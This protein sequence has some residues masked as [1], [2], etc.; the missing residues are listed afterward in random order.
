MS[1]ERILILAV[2]AAAAVTA[3]FPVPSVEARQSGGTVVVLTGSDPT[4]PIP[5]VGTSSSSNADVADQLFLRLVGLGSSLRTAGDDAMV[6]QLAA[7]WRRID[8]VTVLFELDPRARW[9]DGVPVTAEDVAFTWTLMT[10]P[11]L[12]SNAA[13]LEPIA[14]VEA[15][16]RGTVR[17]RYRRPFNEQVYL[18]G[19]NIQPVPAHL[20]RGIR[21]EE[22]AT[23]AFAARPVGNGPFRWERRVP[24]Q[25]VELRADTAFFLGRP[26]IAKVMFRYAQSEEARLNL[27]LSGSADVMPAVPQS[28]EQQ[29]ER[30]PEYRIVR[31][32]NNLIQYVLF[33]TRNPADTSRSH[34]ALSD[35]RVRNALT[36]ALDRRTMAQSVFGQGV[37]VPEAVQSQILMWAAPD[38]LEATGFDPARA[39]ALLRE[40][41]WTDTDGDGLVDRNGR[42]LR[43]VMIYPASSGFRHAMAIQA[44]RMWREIGVAVTLDRVDF[45]NYGQRRNSGQWDIE[46]G[47][48]EQQ[49]TPSSLVQSW[50]CAAARSPGSSNIAKWCDPEFDRL[51]AAA[52][53]SS[54]PATEYAAAMRQMA[55]QRPVA[56]VAAPPNKV[57]VHS[58][59]ESVTIQPA[60]AWTDLWRWRV[61]PGA[62]LPRDR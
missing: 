57:A 2:T 15:V 39:R 5:V 11:V 35:I 51:L 3:L 55:E 59:Y 48:A 62:E 9:H 40:A 24:G 41:G 13:P 31:V 26:G 56:P 16:D 14:A 33:N 43:M 60:R 42:P 21:P 47:G 20:L 17:V 52:A 46:F 34:P 1:R 19:F 36:L 50:S 37:V 54:S 8:S 58:R 32:P 22:I 28:A 61:R 25:F 49:P 27:L 44:E 12:V 6:P 53:R 38:G 23:S 4:V 30:H 29:I 7:R 45:A 18:A 10:N